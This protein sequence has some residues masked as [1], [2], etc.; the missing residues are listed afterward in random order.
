MDYVINF[1]LNFSFYIS[2]PV[3]IRYMILRRPIKSKWI[4]VSILALLFIGFSVLINAQ[5]EA[6]IRNIYQEANLP[7]KPRPHM[8][9]SPILI[10]A[11]IISYNIMRR[12]K[13]NS[14]T[15]KGSPKK[16]AAYTN[17]SDQKEVGNPALESHSIKAVHP[18]N[19]NK[20]PP[21]TVVDEDRVY[22]E[23]AQELETGISDKGL[24]TRLFADCGGDEKQTKVLYIKQRAERLI[25][26]ERLRLELAAREHASKLERV[27][28]LLPLPTDAEQA[29]RKHASEI[30]RPE[31]L[32][33][34]P[35]EAQQMQEYG[36][37]FDGQRYSYKHYSYEKFHDAI[38]FAKLQER[39]ETGAD[40][41]LREG[42]VEPGN[43]QHALKISAT[44]NQ[45][46]QNRQADS[47]AKIIPSNPMID[48]RLAKRIEQVHTEID[49]AYER[50]R[51]NLGFKQ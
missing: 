22:T 31:K 23:I 34:S 42:V 21:Q 49:N 43:V 26:A 15:V 50:A 45:T 18:A 10:M 1:L 29:T 13:K 48:V 47:M 24:W 25:T 20:S 19:Y 46:P 44:T 51:K 16:K 6:A 14:V 40:R 4:T 39:R 38:N 33:P 7:Y 32:H 30:A 3:V 9:G 37:T 27:E 5:K 36:I 17:F 2:V 28:K 8:I 11:M 41:P 35:T 12:E